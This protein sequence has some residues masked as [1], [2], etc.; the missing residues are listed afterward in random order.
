[1]MIDLLGL[2]TAEKAGSETRFKQGIRYVQ[3]QSF[4][5][6]AGNPIVG[7]QLGIQ[8]SLEKHSQITAEL[9]NSRGPW[10]RSVSLNFYL[11]GSTSKKIR[12]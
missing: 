1:M 8:L 9:R 7:I 5:K 6:V 10:S 2:V 11:W 4:I 3:S 12:V